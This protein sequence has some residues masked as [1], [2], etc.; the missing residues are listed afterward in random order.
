MVEKVS[1]LVPR[2]GLLLWLVILPYTALAH[3]LDEYLQ[4][5]LVTIERS[6]ARFQINFTPGVAVA[7]RVLA[8]IDR[9][10]DG[11]ISTNETVAYADLVRRHLTVAVDGHK[12][13]LSLT[14][15]NFPAVTELRTGWGI[16]Q[17][18]FSA[19][20]GPFQIGAHKLTF[21]NR[22]LPALSVYLFNAAQPSS[23]SVQ[24]TKQTRNQEQSTGEIE[25]V[26]T[27]LESSRAAGRRVQ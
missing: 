17:L 26:I 10:L 16:I 7:E 20:V 13:A 18:E 9:D 11:V 5:T 19:R 2:L 21:K 8:L 14:A 23:R 1:A 6:E 27:Q 4:A 24:I 12:L 15:S 3:R 25:F 22:H